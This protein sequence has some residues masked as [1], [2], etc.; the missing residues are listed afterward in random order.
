MAD[1]ERCWV[2]RCICASVSARDASFDVVVVRHFVERHKMSGTARLIPLAVRRASIIDVGER[3][4][5]PRTEL[6]PTQPDDTFVLFPGGAPIESASRIERLVVIDGTWAQARRMRTRL[7][8]IANLRA[9]SVPAGPPLGRLR[10]P[11]YP[12]E[13][14]TAIAV[15]RAL[16]LRGDSKASTELEELYLRMH[17]VLTDR[18]RSRRAQPR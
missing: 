11:R 14:P 17:A 9:L 1:C 6:D 8:M 13:L 5:T 16:A 10:H 4:A 15:A 7:P 2:P 12:D 18:G 3:N